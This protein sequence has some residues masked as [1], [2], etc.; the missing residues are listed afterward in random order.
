MIDTL[1]THAADIKTQLTK[2]GFAIPPQTHIDTHKIKQIHRD[3]C[4]CT[5]EVIGHSQDNLYHNVQTLLWHTTCI[6]TRVQTLDDVLKATTYLL[7]YLKRY[8]G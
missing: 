3:F 1:V 2:L 7:Q 5:S 4:H 8:N 6:Y